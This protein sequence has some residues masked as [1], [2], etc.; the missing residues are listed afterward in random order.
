MSE[1]YAAGARP[2]LVKAGTGASNISASKVMF[3][4]G[5]SCV[6]IWETL[7]APSTLSLGQVTLT[8]NVWT[9][10]ISHTVIGSGLGAPVCMYSW[11]IDRLQLASFNR[12]VR[13][14]L[15]GSIIA[16]DTG[17]FTTG[18]WEVTLDPGQRV[19]RN[20]DLLLVQAYTNG[21]NRTS[22]RNVDG[23]NLN[24]YI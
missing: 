20:G 6:Q 7:K 19:L 21:T 12:Q 10:L 16:S 24:L 3:G 11:G 13:L 8:Q 22:A 9:T 17:T 4:T 14:M 1:L 15:N 2:Y 5:S 18:G 23:S